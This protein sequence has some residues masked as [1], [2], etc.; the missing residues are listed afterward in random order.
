MIRTSLSLKML[1]SIALALSFLSLALAI[2]QQR[3]EAYYNEGRRK[4]LEGNS[5]QALNSFQKAIDSEPDQPLFY[6]AHAL[7]ATNKVLGITMPSQSWKGLPELTGVDAALLRM[8]AADYNSALSFSRDD[9]TFWSNLGW[10]DALLKNDDA[11]L[12]AF[13]Q[14]VLMDPNDAVSRIG[15]GLFY[16]RRGSIEA[17]LDEYAHSLVA[18]PRIVDS[19]FFT[20]LEAR[21]RSGAPAVVVRSLDILSASPQ[22][23]IVLA[24][25]AKLH[26]YQGQYE[27][28]RREYI[29]A[30]SELPNLSYVWTNL[31]L[32]DLTQGRNRAASINFKRA[33]FLDKQNMIAVSK[34]ASIKFENGEIETAKRL[35]ARTLVTPLTSVHA[36][37]TWRIYHVPTIGADDIT[38]AGLLYYIHP[39]S[40]PLSLCGDWLT[41]LTRLAGLSVQVRSK[42]QTQERLC[43]QQ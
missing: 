37:R 7:A 25:M 15:L 1:A 18:F 26:A 38:P 2:S 31:G 4:L 30:L 9:A 29:S 40:Q 21:N 19:P 28:A 20:D 41:H 14:A 16:E 34:L 32:L 35:Y 33:Q 6:A 24:S 36:E 8:A 43:N 10:V 42:V 17:A 23:P 3:S 39:N 11:S 22:S 12:A 13:R 27:V 5:L